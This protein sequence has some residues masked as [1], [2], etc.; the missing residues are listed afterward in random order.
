MND[1]KFYYIIDALAPFILPKSIRVGQVINWSKIPFFLLEKNGTIP[2]IQSKQIEHR[3]ET[4]TNKVSS[5]G[6]N[7]IS[8]DDLAHLSILQS[9]SSSLKEKIEHYRTIFHKLF[10][11]AQSHNLNIFINTDAAFAPEGVSLSA[12]KAID[13]F[14]M[15]CRDLFITFPR[16]SGIILRLGECDGVDVR[17][18]LKSNLVFQKSRHIRDLV[19]ELVKL[20]SYYNKTLIVRTWTV[21]AYEIGDLM[22]NQS[23]YKKI[24]GGI[25]SENL[26]V[27]HKYGDTD[28]FRYLQLNPLIF[29]GEQKKIVEF[30]ARREYEG[31][32]EFPSFV[33]YDYEKY[34]DKLIDH[35]G[36]AGIHV[37]CQTGGWSRFHKVT[38]M[39]GSSIWNE[40]NTE[41][42]V[43]L[44]EK[45]ES[46]TSLIS[47]ISEHK[48]PQKN[49]EYL[50]QLL[51]ISDD[52][53]KNSGICLSFQ[54]RVSISE[55]LEYLP[56]SGFSGIQ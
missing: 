52:V 36:F 9:Y 49:P 42:T 1:H 32:G 41:I 43:K 5:I 26:L 44:F 55:D 47:D 24:F 38:Y 7:S 23:T 3:F 33:G 4:Y 45:K 53:I 35:E 27:S 10:S 8:I 21:G 28:F 17:G 19:T 46:I 25:C 6:Y 29:Y 15:L 51:Q 13:R 18:E 39:P 11:T 31:F 48:F 37:W 20:F 56:L 16:V 34:R 12:T 14:V 30:Q 22:W 40:I 50:Q 2:D 54:V